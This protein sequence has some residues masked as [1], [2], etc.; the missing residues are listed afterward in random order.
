MKYTFIAIFLMLGV[1]M[2]AQ[3]KVSFV[4]PTTNGSKFRIGNKL[5]QLTGGVLLNLIPPSIR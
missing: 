4:K 3:Y 5:L 2:Q 1:T